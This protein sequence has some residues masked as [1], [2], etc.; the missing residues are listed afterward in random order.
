MDS[1][2]KIGNAPLPLY[3]L[4]AEEMTQLAPRKKALLKEIF[5][6]MDTRELKKIDAMELYTILLIL[7][8]ADYDSVL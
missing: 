3:F 7:G 2:S 5:K 1:L 8:K 6:V 4:N